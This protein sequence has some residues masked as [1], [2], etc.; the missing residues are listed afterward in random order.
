MTN[1][2]PAYEPLSVALAD[3]LECS[4]EE[5]PKALAERVAALSPPHW[6]VLEPHQRHALLAQHDAQHDP[7]CHEA[8]ERAFD[9][10]C[11]LQAVDRRMAERE[12]LAAPTH[13]EADSRDAALLRLAQERTKLERELEALCGESTPLVE[14]ATAEANHRDEA[15]VT[16]N[17]KQREHARQRWDTDTHERGAQ[18][19][20]AFALTIWSEDPSCDHATMARRVRGHEI[21]GGALPH[22]WVRESVMLAA[23]RDAAEQHGYPVRGKRRPPT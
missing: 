17:D 16:E 10:T 21:P 13:L 15:L 11:Q 8:Q 19:A 7:A 20:V 12:T 1:Q 6:D 2:D 18:K 3:R 9:L 5:L 14:T 4:F 22:S 23:F